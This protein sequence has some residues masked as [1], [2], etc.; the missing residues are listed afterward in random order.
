VDIEEFVKQ[1]KEAGLNYAV[2][3]NWKQ[4]TPTWEDFD[5]VSSNEDTRIDLAHLDYP[6]NFKE[7]ENEAAKAYSKKSYNFYIYRSNSYRNKNAVGPGTSLHFDENDILHWQCRG[8]TI[9][10]LGEVTEDPN[11]E[12]SHNGTFTENFH[13]VLLEPGDLMWL[14]A[15]TWHETENITE[16]RSLVY[17]VYSSDDVRVYNFFDGEKTISFNKTYK[18]FDGEKFVI[19]YGLD[20]EKR[21]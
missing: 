2:L 13:E 18:L 15:K 12:R 14:N 7:F 19:G 6:E 20:D 21:G 8:A 1:S 16:K 3:R 10:R 5:L 17:E 11:K 4:P 9:W